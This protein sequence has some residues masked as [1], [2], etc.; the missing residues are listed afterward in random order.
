MVSK[1][2]EKQ[3]YWTIPRCH[4]VM[5]LNTGFKLFES[6]EASSEPGVYI[7]LLAVR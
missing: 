7:R 2:F 6:M 3:S 5:I 1:L 4:F